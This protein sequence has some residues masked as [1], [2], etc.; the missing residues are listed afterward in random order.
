RHRLLAGAGV[1]RHDIRLADEP[2]GL[3]G[4]QLGVAGDDAHP[5]EASRGRR[6][7]ASSSGCARA[8]RAAAAIAEPPRRPWTTSHGTGPPGRWC[9]SRAT[10][11][12]ADPTKPTGIPTIAAGRGAPSWSI[13]SRWN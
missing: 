7:H 11:D 12:S 8:L 5:V 10:L 2:G 6:A 13:S 1:V 3:E 9:S 4:D